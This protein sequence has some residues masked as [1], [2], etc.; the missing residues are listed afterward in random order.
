[1]TDKRN[2]TNILKIST[3]HKIYYINKYNIILIKHSYVL[4]K[5]LK[6]RMSKYPIKFEHIAK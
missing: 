6:N 2:F 5:I 1:M 3:N 4:I